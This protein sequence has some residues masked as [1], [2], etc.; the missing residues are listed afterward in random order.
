MANDKDGWKNWLIASLWTI[1]IIL[2]GLGYNSIKESLDKNYA[3]QVNHSKEW[4]D[5]KIEYTNHQSLIW[6]TLDRICDY[7]GDRLRK[8]G[9][10][11]NYNIFDRVK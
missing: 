8:E 2:G 6:R 10:T 9:K 4:A 3:F 7:Q 5:W 1:T 11:P